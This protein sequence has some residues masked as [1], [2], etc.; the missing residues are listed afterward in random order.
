MGSVKETSKKFTAAML[1]KVQNLVHTAGKVKDIIY[2]RQY[3]TGS[4]FYWSLT[5]KILCFWIASQLW[6]VV[7]YNVQEWVSHGTYH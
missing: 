6:E 7:T 4:S 2:K 1:E 5:G 3:L